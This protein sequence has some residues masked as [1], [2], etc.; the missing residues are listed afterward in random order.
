MAILEV[1]GVGLHHIRTV[2]FFAVPEQH[3]E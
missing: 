2:N 3:A 1:K